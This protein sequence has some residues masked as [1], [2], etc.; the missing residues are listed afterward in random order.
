MKT[1][2]FIVIADTKITSP[3]PSCLKDMVTGTKGLGAE[4]LMASSIYH[5]H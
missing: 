4:G 5:T 2:I 1:C 3:A